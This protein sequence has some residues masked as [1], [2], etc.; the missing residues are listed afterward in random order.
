VAHSLFFIHLVL[1][2]LHVYSVEILKTSTWSLSTNMTTPNWSMGVGSLHEKIYVVGGQTQPYQ[3]GILKSI[4]IFH[5][6]K[7]EWTMGANMSTLRVGLNVATL[8][9]SIY[10]AGGW[11]VGIGMIRAQILCRD[12][13]LTFFPEKRFFFW[14][15]NAM[16]L[17]F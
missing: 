1:F 12:F 11:N 17:P 10:A 8:N 7:N 2:V 4:S 5:P 15:F 14:L 16:K 9:G 3:D 6:Q 13:F